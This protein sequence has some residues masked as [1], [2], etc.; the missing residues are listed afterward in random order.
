[1]YG[2]VNSQVWADASESTE[3]P[4]LGGEPPLEG[5]TQ[6]LLTKMDNAQVDGALIVQ[7]I[8]HK[9][10]HRYVNKAIKVYSFITKNYRNHD[11]KKKKDIF[12]RLTPIEC[13]VKCLFTFLLY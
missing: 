9:F 4:Y 6:L 2:Y 12:Y 5:S 1:M 13:K 11:G 3:F 7:P 10:D 8:N